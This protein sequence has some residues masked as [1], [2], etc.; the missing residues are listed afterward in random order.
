DPLTLHSN[1]FSSFFDI[2][3]LNPCLRVYFFTGL[4]EGVRYYEPKEHGEEKHYAKVYRR[5]EQ[6]KHGGKASP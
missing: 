4:L 3:P 6:L 2:S 1:D 5:L